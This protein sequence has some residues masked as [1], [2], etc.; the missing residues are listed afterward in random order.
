M[1][2]AFL[3][4]LISSLSLVVGGLLGLA[5]PFGRRTLGAIMGFGAGALISA[6]CFELMLKAV[7][8]SFGSG[9]TAAG[10]FTGAAGYLGAEKLVAALGAGDDTETAGAV[11]K[12]NLAIPLI[13][14]TIMMTSVI[15]SPL[16][17]AEFKVNCSS[18]DDCMAKGDKLTKKRKLSLALEAYRNAI[19]M[20]V[21]NKDA[22][23]KFE[24][25]VVRIS[26]EGGC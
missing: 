10:F 13:L 23:R 15:T 25:I 4:C 14:A 8:L 18:V 24:K 7:K 11:H 22:W 3:W 20:D 26:E 5:I 12:S 16:Q 21:E 1:L 9:A 2:E 17:A 19:K 6:V